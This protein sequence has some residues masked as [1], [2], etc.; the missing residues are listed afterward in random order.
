MR[1]KRLLSIA[2]FLKS[3]RNI[4]SA[5]CVRNEARRGKD[6]VKVLENGS[7]VADHAESHVRWILPWLD[8]G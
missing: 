8:G 5:Q 1:E 3:R 7:S 4:I 6:A 2:R